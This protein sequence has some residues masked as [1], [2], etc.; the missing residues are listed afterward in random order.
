MRSSTSYGMQ[1]MVTNDKDHLCTQVVHRLNLRGPSVTVQTTCSTSLVA[2]AMACE[3]LQS[4]ACEMALA[5][6]VTVRVP[7]R[8]GYFYT[9]GR[10]IAVRAC[11]SPRSKRT[12][13]ACFF[14]PRTGANPLRKCSRIRVGRSPLFLRLANALAELWRSW[15]IPARRNDRSQR[16]RVCGCGRGRRDVAARRA[17]F[18]RG[19]RAAYFQSAARVDARGDGAGGNGGA[20][21]RW[22]D[23]ARGGSSTLQAS[24]C[25]P[26]ASGRSRGRRAGGANKGVGCGAASAHF[27]RVPLRDDGTDP[28]GIWKTRVRRTSP[29]LRPRS[30]CAL[31]A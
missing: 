29:L 13:A 12:C 4:G 26:V 5:G 22:R 20:L 14:R 16:R 7:Q 6:G 9:A 25:F 10:S 17:R 18:D 19:A 2:V 31:V 21:C 27:A 24:P 15:G 23:S 3:S 30:L 28:S 11:S 8:G 1:L